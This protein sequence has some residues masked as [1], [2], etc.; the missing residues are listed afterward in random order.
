MTFERYRQIFQNRSFALFWSGFS[1]SVLGDA[2]TRVAL[3]W[4]V[5]QTTGSAEALGWL[6]LCYTGPI[7]VGGLMAGSLLDR[8][9]RRAVMMADNIVR[10]VAVALIPLLYAV[11]WLALW[12]IYAVAAVYGLLM[13]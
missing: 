6:M 9:D 2:M 3:T 1:F 4:F 12:H 7:V 5:Y 10:G 11:G 8:F 13:M